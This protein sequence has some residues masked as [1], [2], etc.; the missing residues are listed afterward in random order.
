MM[1]N[2][3][4][5]FP[6]SFDPITNGHV[7]VVRRSLY[8][9]DQIIIAVGNNSD[10]EYFFPIDE[11]K[12]FVDKTFEGESKVKVCCYRGLTT[13]FCKSK[14]ANIILRGLRN[15][16]DFNYEKVMAQTNRKLSEIETFFVFTS[17]ENS[18]IS[19]SV[20]KEIIRGKGDYKLF[21]PSAVRV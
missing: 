14:K 18:F 1:K 6:G 7:D 15:V 19:S 4:A 21:V 20:V 2:K 9:F 3:V 17:I 8:L 11:R 10:K 16:S 12:Y 5:V 13:D